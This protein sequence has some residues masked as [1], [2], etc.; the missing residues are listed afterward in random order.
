M[1]HQATRSR[2]NDMRLLSKRNRLR[3]HIQTSHNDSASQ[4]NQRSQRL[5]GLTDLGRQLAGRGENEAE[6]RLRLV[7]ESLENG[8]GESSSLST[9]GLCEADNVATLESDGDGLFL[10]RGRVLVIEGLAGFAESVV[11][12]LGPY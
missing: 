6:Q 3:N 12:T 7:E 11:D 4:R 2:N 5:K 8:E 9:T 1:V 10:D